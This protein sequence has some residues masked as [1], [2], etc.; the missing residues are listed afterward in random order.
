MDPVTM[1]I[2]AAIAAGAGAGAKDVAAQ[3]IVDGYQA[4][5]ALLKRKFGD[6]SDAVKALDGLESKPES[7]GRKRTVSEE[8]AAVKAA[9][10]PDLLK[11]AQTLIEQLKTQPGG[12]RYIQQTAEGNYIAQAAQGS[13]AAVNISGNIPGR[14]DG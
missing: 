4:L 9:D 10:D 12:E 8:L 1:A 5:K 7:E 13:T 2:I 3:V 11:A 14:K 6:S